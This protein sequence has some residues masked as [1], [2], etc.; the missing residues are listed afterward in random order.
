M[1]TTTIEIES[2]ARLCGL[3]QRSPKAIR[4]TAESI[5]IRPAFVINGVPHFTPEQAD[6][7]ADSLRQRETSK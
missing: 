1:D 3:F 5:G 4:D 6:L 7:I 2:V